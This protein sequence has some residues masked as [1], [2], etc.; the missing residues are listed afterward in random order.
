MILLTS[1]RGLYGSADY[2][3][4]AASKGAMIA[5]TKSLA[6]ALGRDGVTVNGLNPGMTDTPLARGAITP[7]SWR[8]KESYDVMGSHSIPE[9]IAEIVLFLAGTAGR[10]MTGQIVAT[11]MRSIA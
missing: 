3:H 8:A 9:D 11:R 2:A 7:E 4:Y 1:D 5:L 10:F 6:I